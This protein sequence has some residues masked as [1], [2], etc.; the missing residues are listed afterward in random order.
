MKKT[1]LIFT[2]LLLTVSNTQG[3]TVK[4]GKLLGGTAS[5]KLDSGDFSLDVY[6]D[7]GY[8]INEN[9]ALGSSAAIS[10]VDDG[11][12]IGISPL[13]RYYF[14]KND[15]TRFFGHANINFKLSSKNIEYV[16]DIYLGLG[17]VWFISEKTGLESMLRVDDNGEIGLHFGFQIYFN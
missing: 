15:K 5:F 17:H 4:G 13:A 9:L 11:H 14:G 6:P 10:I 2:L 8:F 7:F 12:F 16:R 1:I 3:Q